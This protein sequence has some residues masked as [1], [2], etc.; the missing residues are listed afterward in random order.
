[1]SDLLI[2]P[3]FQSSAVPFVAALLA[4]ALLGFGG[5][6]QFTGLAVLAGFLAASLLIFGLPVLPPV[7]S[8]HKI[9]YVAVLGAAVGLILD[10]TNPDLRKRLAAGLSAVIVAVAW[11]G[12]RKLFAAPSPDHLWMLLVVAGAVLALWCGERNSERFDPLEALAVLLVAALGL[13][14]VA[15]IGASAS[16]SQNAGALAAALGG[17]MVL[18]WPARRFGL[19]ATARLTALVTLAALAAQLALF[20]RAPAWS[21]L[22]LLPAFLAPRLAH[23]LIPHTHPHA[24]LLRPVLTGVI[25]AVPAALATA[26][27]WL[28]APA[29]SG[30]Y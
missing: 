16:T 9:P 1:M 17:L 5:A 25:T 8:G 30:G 2:N 27:A 6:K 13:A 19:G 11:L 22:L 29:S 21:L 26:A 28:A 18:N 23:R 20:S 4:A 7:A 10:L 12:W 14:G 3:A 24:A 15:V